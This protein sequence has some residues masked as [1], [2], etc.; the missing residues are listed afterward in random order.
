MNVK[1]GDVVLLHRQ[2]GSGHEVK[3]VK[4]AKVTPTGRIR[5]LGHSRAW[6]N[7]DGVLSS[8]DAVFGTT[9]ITEA[10]DSELQA[11]K[12]KKFR[13]K[14]YWSMIN[15]EPETLTYEKAVG[16]AKAMGWEMPDGEDTENHSNG[17]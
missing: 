8:R 6:F 16:V 15:V 1:T 5:L 11:Y 13:I 9:Y 10:N 7:K 4:V 17:L 14:T 2:T 12:R 3:L